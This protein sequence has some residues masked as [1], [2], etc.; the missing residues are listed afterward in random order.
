MTVLAGILLP[1]SVLHSAW[2]QAL[3]AFVALNT[4]IFALLALGKLI[5][6]RRA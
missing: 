6:R 2:Y 4:L 1:T 3:A 5:P